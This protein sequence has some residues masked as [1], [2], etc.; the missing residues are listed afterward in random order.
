[1]GSTCAVQLTLTEYGAVPK[2]DV[3]LAAGGCAKATKLVTKSKAFKRKFLFIAFL[4]FWISVES[5]MSIALC[6]Y[7]RFSLEQ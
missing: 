6:K 2:I 3:R 4:V 7:R 1:V 5:N